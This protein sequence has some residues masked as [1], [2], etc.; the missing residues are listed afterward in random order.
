MRVRLPNKPKPNTDRDE[1]ARTRYSKYGGMRMILYCC[2]KAGEQR[3]DCWFMAE[4]TTVKRVLSNEKLIRAGYFDLSEA[5]EHIQSACIGHAVYRT[6]RTV[7][8][9]D[10]GQSPPS[11]SVLVKACGKSTTFYAF[12]S[13][14][15]T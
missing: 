1:A 10:G 7:R 12:F 3:K 2:A 9:E 8:R 6:E 5:Y 11:Y 14:C 15:I 13:K 4:T